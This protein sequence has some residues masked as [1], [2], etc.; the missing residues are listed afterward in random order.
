M[1]KILVIYPFFA[2]YVQK[3]YAT[4]GYDPLI[5]RLIAASGLS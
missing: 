1:M 3:S 2:F 4:Q 5:N